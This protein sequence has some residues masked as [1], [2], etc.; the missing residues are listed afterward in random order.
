VTYIGATGSKDGGTPAQ[1]VT[2]R[3]FLL[4][5][6][7]ELHHGMCIGVDKQAHD[8]V[9]EL[10]ANDLTKGSRW[11]AG[12]PGFNPVK[13]DDLS[14][15]ADCTGL[16]ETWKPKP[17]PDRNRDIVDAC[18]LLVAVPSTNDEQLRSGTWATVRYADRIG[19]L[20]LIILRDG[21]IKPYPYRKG[22]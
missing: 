1:L 15:R 10:N 22:E 3:Q 19:K 4:P 13:P 7:T 21:S 11:I 16:N 20:V 6:S 8:I 5:V 2:L 12:H 18:D 9:L 14:K 17:F